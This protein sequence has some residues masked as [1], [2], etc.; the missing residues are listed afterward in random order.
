MLLVK[1][2][3]RGAAVRSVGAAVAR[4]ASARAHA[5]VSFSVDVDPQ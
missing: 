1:A 3:E 2:Y 4:E 5:R